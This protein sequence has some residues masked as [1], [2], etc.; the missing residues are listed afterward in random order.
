MLSTPHRWQFS[1]KDSTRNL[2][3][4]GSLLGIGV[5]LVVMYR[6]GALDEYKPWSIA[7]FT[8]L[9]V[10]VIVNVFAEHFGQRRND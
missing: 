7:G 8:A 9:G 3:R 4:C 1:M 2:M 10:L 5:V 6:S